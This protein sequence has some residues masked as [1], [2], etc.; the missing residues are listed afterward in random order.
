MDKTSVEIY[1]HKKLALQRGE[2][3]VLQ[4]I[5]RGKDIMSILR[6]CSPDFFGNLVLT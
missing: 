6:M 5:G 2:E 4:Q 3:A 1:E